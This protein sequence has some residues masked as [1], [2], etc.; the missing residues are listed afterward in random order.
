[1]GCLAHFKAQLRRE[2]LPWP[3]GRSLHDIDDAWCEVFGTSS[4]R[5]SALSDRQLYVRFR[6]LLTLC[7]SA[8]WV[9]ALASDFGG[10]CHNSRGGKFLIF[11]TN[12]TLTA[13][14]IYFWF[15]LWTTVQA[16]AH[17]NACTAAGS[18]SGGVSASMPPSAPWFVRVT[19]ALHAI[20]LN[21]SFAVVVLYWGM[22]VPASGPPN[23]AVGYFVHGVNFVLALADMYASSQPYYVAHI[24]LY[25]AYFSCYVLFSLLYFWC[26]GT[27]CGSAALPGGD[28]YI[29]P[30]L[31]WRKPGKTVA[32]G[33]GVLFVVI[34]LLTAALFAA[35]RRFPGNRRFKSPDS[36]SL[37]TSSAVAIAGDG[38]YAAI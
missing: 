16:N 36:G 24:T 26:G 8:I 5:S 2:L 20:A 9:W 33:L 29:Y 21:G 12:W 17:L 11:L 7:I 14:T 35:V 38:A 10:G 1:M 15:A 4:N 34:P 25:Y 22:L 23:A 3:L 31:D 37:S 13:E 18:R 32:L 6:A 28:P 27:D 30:V 19:W